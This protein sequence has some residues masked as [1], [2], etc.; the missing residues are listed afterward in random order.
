VLLAQIRLSGSSVQEDLLLPLTDERG[1]PRRLVVLSGAEGVGK[2][3]ILAAI[4]STRPGHSVVQTPRPGA[5]PA[6]AVADWS[7]GDDDP[8]RP[9]P[10]RVLN[11]NARLEIERD[12]EVLARRREQA[13]FDRRAAEGGFAFTTF[14]GARW[15]SRAPLY[16]T[17]PMRTLLR[18]DVR[19]LANF[20]DAT[21]ADLTRET[22]QVLA[23]AGIAAALARAQ[24][25]EPGR[26]ELF[27][28]A[29]HGVLTALLEGTGVTFTG[30]DP[31]RLEPTFNAG[32]RAT[33]L[34]DLPRRARHRIAFGALALRTLAA[35]YPDR[36]PRDAEGV[37]LI[38]DL[39]VQQDLASQSALP[40]L[41]RRALPRAQW[42]VTTSSPAVVAGCD[43]GAVVAL[44]RMTEEGPVE[45]HQG[46]GAVMH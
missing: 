25:G 20:D 13:L 3:A 7:L 39:E 41:L 38:D 1:A 14:S 43:P 31:G 35:A 29:L 40:S 23:F 4:A 26:F 19:T 16:L 36:D 18:H 9:H 24:D 15:F 32:G 11:P 27:E 33:D 45:V 21:H 10:L 30:V 46:A 6:F 42:I 5:P 17:T 2:T 12:D 44:R 28:R 37:I 34:D 22:K 8:K